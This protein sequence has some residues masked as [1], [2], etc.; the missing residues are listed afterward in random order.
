MFEVQFFTATVILKLKVELTAHIKT[1]AGQYVSLVIMADEVISRCLPGGAQGAQRH[2]EVGGAQ[3]PVE[4]AG[5]LLSVQ[6]PVQ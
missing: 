3:D 4:R 6:G 1:G 2:T 5:Q